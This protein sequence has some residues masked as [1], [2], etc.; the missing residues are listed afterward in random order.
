MAVLS[1]VGARVGL[2]AVLLGTPGKCGKGP[3]WYSVVLSAVSQ[4]ADSLRFAGIEFVLAARGFFVLPI[5]LVL[6][7]ARN[8]LHDDKWH[9]CCYVCVKRTSIRT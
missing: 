3:N 7:S 6:R 1:V 5:G 8:L 9:D 2:G 4:P